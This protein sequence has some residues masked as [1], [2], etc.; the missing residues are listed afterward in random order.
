[1]PDEAD[2]SH[3]KTNRP[4][5]LT[6][7]LVHKTTVMGDERDFTLND[8]SLDVF[9]SLGRYRIDAEIARG[10]MGVILK[11]FDE[12]L[13]RDVAIKLLQ[14]Q[15]S[16]DTAFC[17]RFVN[18]ALLTSRL[19]HPCIVPIYDAGIASDERPYFVMKLITGKTLGKI[20][21]VPPQNQLDRSRL[22]KIFEQ[23]CLAMCYA[24]N[25]GVLHLDLKPVNVMVGEF[26]EVHVMDW[27][28][29]RTWPPSF[30]HQH[31]GPAGT[32]GNSTAS[33]VG[34]AAYIAPEQARG[35]QPCPR[36]DVF[37][38]GALL[39]E[40]LTGRPPH[41]GRDYRGMYVRAM[42]GNLSDAI[43][44]LDNCNSD[45]RLIEL[46]KRCLSPDRKERPVDA[47]F[48]AQSVAAYLESALEQAESDLCRF[49]DLSLDMFCT[50]SPDGY[51][52]RIN[53]NFPRVLGY[54][55]QQLVSR[56]FLDFVHPDDTASTQV[57]MQEMAE[58]KPVVRFCNRYRHADGHYIELEWTAQSNRDDGTIFAVARDI[59]SRC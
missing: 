17:Q 4:L 59:S 45:K 53:T 1:M 7:E 42:Q 22:L 55:E 48:V 28:L 35:E 44:R 49:F 58:G 50:A 14:H 16:S 13:H 54:S 38:L 57:V 12:L 9:E 23:V 37:G 18:E 47:Q 27:G 20:L 8:P 41:R 15:Y 56:P 40:I 32:K 5:P 36:T 31:S 26:G 2:K 30:L 29:A 19:Q 11:A 46:A 43:K 33:I 21:D 24:H 52:L 3:T 25:N 51:F 6:A 10:G 34:T 39:C